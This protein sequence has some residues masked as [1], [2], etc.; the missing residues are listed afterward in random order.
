MWV[1]TP[2]RSFVTQSGG[3]DRGKAGC[4]SR[5]PPVLPNPWPFISFQKYNRGRTRRIPESKVDVGLHVYRPY[6][7]TKCVTSNMTGSKGFPSSPTR[8]ASYWL[9]FAGNLRP[10]HASFFIKIS[11]QRQD[12]VI[13]LIGL[14]S[15]PNP[16]PNSIPLIYHNVVPYYIN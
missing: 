15:I 4:Q 3:A 16:A 14:V 7:R 9:K 1:K 8:K 5:P 11:W 2:A 12:S 10:K 6:I 13:Y